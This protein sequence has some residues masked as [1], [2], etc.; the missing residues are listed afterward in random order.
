MT[1]LLCE[2]RLPLESLLFWW[3]SEKLLQSLMSFFPLFL[4]L[5]VYTAL[6][7]FPNV[8]GHIFSFMYLFL[9]VVLAYS[10][11]LCLLTSRM[12][13]WAGNFFLAFL[14]P[15]EISF[16]LLRLTPT[17]LVALYS[18]LSHNRLRSKSYI[19]E[20]SCK[21][22]LKIHKMFYVFLKRH[23]ALVLSNGLYTL[24]KTLYMD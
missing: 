11:K 21:I 20:F 9:F 18:N 3:S 8:L 23:D 10:R 17:G 12:S 16:C 5:S 2:W 22:S 15:S 19:V 6:L 1:F 7:F 14:V 24:L 4:D 13:V